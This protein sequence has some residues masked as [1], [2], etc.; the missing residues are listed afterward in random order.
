MFTQKSLE[1]KKFWAACLLIGID[2]NL[3][4]QQV[5]G[6]GGKSDQSKQMIKSGMNTKLQNIYTARIR[7]ESNL[8]QKMVPQTGIEPVTNC[9]EGSC[10]IL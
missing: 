4:C 5:R 1:Y 7:I 6:T 2:N 8:R 9:L 3:L 10:S